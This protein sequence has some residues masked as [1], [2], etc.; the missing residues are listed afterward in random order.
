MKK[1]ILYCD[2]DG[3]IVDYDKFKHLSEDQK[4]EQGFFAN[5]PAIEG[6]IEAFKKLNEHF[7]VYILSTAPWSNTHAWSEKR[8]WVE[9][10]LGEFAFKRLILSHNKGLLKGKYLIDDRLMNGVTEFEG[11]HIHFGSP[12][13]PNWHSVL[14][15]LMNKTSVFI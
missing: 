4:R 2:L 1:E 12:C 11:E 3:V 9:Q 8:I 10:H 13:F 15:Y 14:D 5:L 7:D 6:S